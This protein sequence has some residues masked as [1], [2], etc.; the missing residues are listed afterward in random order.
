VGRDRLTRTLDDNAVIDNTMTWLY[1]CVWA[2]HGAADHVI[3]LRKVAE[4]SLPDNGLEDPLLYFK[5][6]FRHFNAE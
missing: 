2:E 1:C 3:V 6:R 4:M 5:G